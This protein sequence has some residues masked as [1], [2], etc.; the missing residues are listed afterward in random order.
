[1][2]PSKRIV[3][4]H[5]S[6]V[7]PFTGRHARVVLDPAAVRVL[8]GVASSFLHLFGNS[9]RIFNQARSCSIALDMDEPT[10]R[11]AE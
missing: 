5:Q 3:S 1:M 2:L 7:L 6:R 10:V 8:R 11:A 4:L 9:Q